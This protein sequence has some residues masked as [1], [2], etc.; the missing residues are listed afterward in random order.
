VFENS[1]TET[2]GQKYGCNKVFSWCV[3]C[4]A[5]F[6]NILAMS[7][8]FVLLVEEIGVPEATI[9]YN[10]QIRC[11]HEGMVVGFTTI[12]AISAYNH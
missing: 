5:N 12:C 3:R 2:I 10:S 6:N 8:Q 1:S 4:T 7:W 11:G 9:F